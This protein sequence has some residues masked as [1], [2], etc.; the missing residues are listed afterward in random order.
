MNWET[1]TKEA[2]KE[3]AWSS[4]TILDSDAKVLMNTVPL[5]EESIGNS[6]NLLETIYKSRDD[7]VRSGIRWNKVHYD[8]YQWSENR[9]VFGRVPDRVDCDG[10]AILKHKDKF[11]IITYKYP[12]TTPLA[13]HTLEKFIDTNI[14]K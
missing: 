8:V 7:A 9:L 2:E 3:R 11:Y 5:D 4:L 10:C 13:V 14:D 12:I 1:I 6:K